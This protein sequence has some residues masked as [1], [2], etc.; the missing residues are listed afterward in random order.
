M[1]TQTERKK[2][3]SRLRLRLRLTC[4][5]VESPRPTGADAKFSDALHGRFLDGVVARESQVVVGRQVQ[6]F[7]TVHRHVLARLGKINKK[8]CSALP[9]EIPRI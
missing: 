5:P 4:C 1:E 3:K 8:Y 9:T 6:A 7:V 2:G